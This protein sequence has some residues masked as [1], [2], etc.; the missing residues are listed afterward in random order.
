LG[1]LGIDGRKILKWV[2]NEQ[3]MRV[4]TVAIWFRIGISGGHL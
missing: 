3:D 4:W 1:D 2:I